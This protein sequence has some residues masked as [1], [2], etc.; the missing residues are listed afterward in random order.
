MFDVDQITLTS[1]VADVQAINASGTGTICTLTMAAID[2]SSEIT[3]WTV[4][5][6]SPV[7]FGSVVVTSAV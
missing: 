6:R 7:K 2:P 1:L 5:E 3:K 4:Y